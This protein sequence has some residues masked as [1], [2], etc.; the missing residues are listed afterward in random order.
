MDREVTDG[1]VLRRLMWLF[2]VLA[3]TCLLAGAS[4]MRPPGW[5]LAAFG[6][7]L[8]IREALSMFVFAPAIC[9]LFWLM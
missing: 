2:A 6:D 3:G 9:A 7:V 4:R 1:A 8:R 5:Q